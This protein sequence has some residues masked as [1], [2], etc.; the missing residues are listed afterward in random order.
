MQRLLTVALLA[1][2]TNVS[3]LGA[4]QAHSA[5]AVKGPK[6]GFGAGV[7]D[8]LRAIEAAR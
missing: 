5:H 2:V 8:A 6:R 3:A 4:A 7:I 1:V